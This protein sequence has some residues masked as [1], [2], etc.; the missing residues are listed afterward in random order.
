AVAVAVAVGATG[1]VWWLRDEPAP[2]ESSPARELSVATVA[3]SADPA[4]ARCP[5]ATVALVATIGTNGAAGSVSV[6]WTLP[7]GSSGP[8]Q[9]FAVEDGQREIVARLDITLTGSNAVA[10]DA[11]A[12]V[13][14]SGLR[15]RT[16]V[17]YRCPDGGRQ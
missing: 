17:T 12:V 8:G 9:S 10:G 5:R 1:A 11:V 16:R 13:R 3:V 2:A 15:A 4:V 7:D 6:A 14:P